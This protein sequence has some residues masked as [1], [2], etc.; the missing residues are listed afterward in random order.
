MDSR[1]VGNIA[2]LA[3]WFF[4]LSWTILWN[5]E[6]EKMP[7]KIREFFLLRDK[8]KRTSKKPLI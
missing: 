3:V 1:I 2:F 6:G 4:A 8:K 5:P 7:D